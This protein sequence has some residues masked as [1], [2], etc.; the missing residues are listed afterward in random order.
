MN[1][2]S[3]VTIQ[4]TYPL[5]GTLT[6]PDE[7]R[8]NFP[9][10]LI[11]SGSGKWDRDGNMNKME[12]NLYKELAHF[13]TLNGFVTLRY[14]KRGT[15]QS[16]GNY[17]ETGLYDLI[18]DA[19]ECVNFLKI[20]PKVDNEKIFILGHSEGAL[21]TPAVHKKAPVSGLILLA[22]AAKPS[23]ELLARQNEKAYAE[24]NQTRGIKGLLYRTFK[25]AE[26]ARKQN[27]KIL[28]KVAESDKAVMRVQGVKINA[29][30]LRET[31][32]YNVC[33]YF[34][35]V[36]CPILAI[37]GAKDV[38]VPPEDVKHIPELVKGEVQWYILSDMNHFL[39]KYKGQH[40][41]LGQMKEYK[42][43]LNQSIDSD[44]LDEIGK[45]LKKIKQYTDVEKSI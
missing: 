7:A 41:M 43:Q 12:M 17:L 30:C 36:N 21:I 45:W 35:E 1:K 14:D 15:Y 22:G 24:M 33:H 40:T 13:L 4:A 27:E 6:F 28:T 42:S 9:A 34:N 10:V 8:K 16:G 39:R 25:A 18:D 38:Q 32:S 44:L 2:S 5:G 37:S 31:L 11:I 19:T 29:K 26:K 20:H 23:R 3:E